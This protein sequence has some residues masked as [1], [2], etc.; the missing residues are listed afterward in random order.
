MDR[1]SGAGT[2]RSQPRGGGGAPAEGVAPR[3]AQGGETLTTAAGGPVDD[4]DNSLRVGARGPTLL[5]DFHLREKIMHF[6]HERIPERVVH[7]RGAAAHGVF[8]L[9][10]AIE[11]LT[12]APILCDTSTE[13]PVFV[14]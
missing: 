8:R 3:W 13:T 2:R 1:S 10:E 5:D 12:L 7:A 9:T 11:P 6:D 14:R 4:T